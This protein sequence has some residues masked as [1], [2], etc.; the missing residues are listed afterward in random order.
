MKNNVLKYALIITLS[1]GSKLFAQIKPDIDKIDNAVVVVMI[2][3]YKGNQVGHGSGFIID[4]KGTVVTNYHVVKGASSLKVKIDNNG[5][6]EVY[7]VENILSGDASKDLAKISIKNLYSKKF[8][9]LTLSKTFP[10]KGEDCWAIGTPADEKYMNTVSRG[11]VSNIDQYS[12]PKILQTN[13]EITHGSS[14]GALINAKGEVI[15]VTSAGDGTEDGARASINFA[16]WI[17]ELNNLTPINKKTVVDPASIPCQLGFYTNSPYTGYVYFYID[18]IYV[19]SFSKYFQNNY[20]PT[21]GDD[22]TITRYLYAGTHSYQVYF[23]STGQWYN[24]TIT[25]SPGQCQMFRVG[26]VTPSQ[27]YYPSSSNNS[28]NNYSQIKDYRFMLGTGFTSVKFITYFKDGK[29]GIQ[30]F[31]GRRKFEQGDV[32]SRKQTAIVQ[33]YGV[34][35]RRVFRSDKRWTHF[36]LGPSLRVINTKLKIDSTSYVGFPLNY[37]SGSRTQKENQIFINGRAGAE[38]VFFNWFAIN[39]DFGL[40]YLT[41][42]YFPGYLTKKNDKLW[43]DIDL[44]IGIRF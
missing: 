6:K 25:L 43:G 34:D 11:L 14:G 4:D 16:I 41:G 8:P 15:G 39:L 5:F 31:W 27:T 44:V 42:N 19:G 21:C 38:F 17:G 29:Y 32:S 13:A 37:V 23:V 20:T 7:E 26:G 28:D 35:F 1:I 9:Y 18:G 33:K 2:Y 24:G 3:D 12:N 36:Y 40:G 22:G 30:G 10:S